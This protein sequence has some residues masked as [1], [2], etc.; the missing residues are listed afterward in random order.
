MVVNKPGLLV[1]EALRISKEPT[2][3]KKERMAPSKPH[4]KIKEEK[5][6]FPSLQ[7]PVADL[8]MLQVNQIHMMFNP[9]LYKIGMTYNDGRTFE[10]GKYAFTD[11]YT[12]TYKPRLTEIQVYFDERE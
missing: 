10:A 5:V 3:A 12:L 4:G 6:T 1:D 7:T 2:I 11:N 8:I 9:N